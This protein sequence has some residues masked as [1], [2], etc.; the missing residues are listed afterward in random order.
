MK[1]TCMSCQHQIHVDDSK[2]PSGVFKVKCSKCGK[3]VTGQ[4][5]TAAH[6]DSAPTSPSVSAADELQAAYS[7]QSPQPP[8]EPLDSGNGDG[9]SELQQLVKREV[10]HLRKELMSSLGALFGQRKDWKLDRHAE[11]EEDDDFARKALVCEDDSAFI[12]IISGSLKRLGYKVEIAKTTA[13]ALKK[14]ETG[15]YNLITVDYTFPDDKEGGVKI[16]A[17]LN[18]QKPGVRRE[19]FVVLISANVKSAD[20]SA[21][22][23][24]GANI[25]V[26]KDEIRHLEY[27]IREGQRHFHELYRVFNRVVE[28]KNEKL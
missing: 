27:L 26:N 24:H 20:A 4:R 8:A 9:N 10:G 18:G 1:L 11:E 5:E 22:F 14:I 15:T 3:I 19:T 12:E 13:E 6:A 25:T 2:I 23:F 17:R 7:M 28:E 21:A 16:I